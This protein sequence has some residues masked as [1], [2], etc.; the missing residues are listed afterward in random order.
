M[1]IHLKKFVFGLTL[2][3]LFS[4]LPS[5]AYSGSDVAGVNQPQTASLLT[6]SGRFYNT[7]KWRGMF[8][9]TGSGGG[10][11]TTDSWTVNQSANGTFT[12]T[13]NPG[14]SWNG[15]FQASVSVADSR[16]R[17]TPPVYNENWQGS[18]TIMNTA[19]LFIDEDSCTYSLSIEPGT[20]PVTHTFG[21]PP[22][23]ETVS[24]EWGPWGL[25]TA[26]RDAPLPASGRTLSSSRQLTNVQTGFG[27]S[28][29]WDITWSFECDTQGAL[30]VTPFRQNDP[31]WR[32]DLYD[33]STDTIWG[34]GCALTSL[35]MAIFYVDLA[36]WTP[37]IVNSNMIAIGGFNGKSVDWSVATHNLSG[38]DNKFHAFRSRS[39]NDV[40]DVLCMGYP[41][42]VGVKL[43]AGGVPGHFVIV[44]GRQGSEFLIS[45]PAGVHTKLSQYGAFETRGFVTKTR[46]NRNSG[47]CGGVQLSQ[48][49]TNA[50]DES[51]LTITAGSNVELLVVDPNG[52]RTGY[53]TSTGD[54]E[55]IPE[56]V[57][58]RDSLAND[59]TGAPPDEITHLVH[60]E[61]P[62]QGSYQIVLT[63]IHHGPY[64]VS[65]EPFS[66]DGSPQTPTLI[67]G[68]APVNS[69]TFPFQY[70]STPGPVTSTVLDN[71]STRALVQTGDNVMI[72][73]FIVQ[74]T[75][76][77][78]VIIRAIGP[79]LG[80][81]PYNIPNALA[82]PRLEL[83]NAAGAV[84]GSN[85]DWQHTTNRRCYHTEPSH[86]HSEQR[87]RSNESIRVGH[88]RRPATG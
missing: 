9:V 55:E 28:G 16:E 65:V 23:N 10:Q 58:F 36:V 87:P 39:T 34:K 25:A 85:D 60:I 20:I 52:R 5:S 13:L 40:D 71:I 73:G 79:E 78:R 43:S 46:W 62:V 33:H 31:R 27:I 2:I 38:G 50:D 54:L 37:R 84:I 1:K 32:A 82:N 19:D 30:P 68:T 42:I 21:P 88:H 22:G 48:A 80:A 59:Q 66:Q 53:R 12:L 56:S 76:P 29:N 63:G 8:T 57:Y 18:G 77:K 67:Q 47:Q 86:R 49:S 44:T 17:I 74:G 51:S 64:S 72:G 3:C 75:G 83:H 41:V 4:W 45:D 6:G 24:Y 14:I 15:S 7:Q 69:S 35:T 26:I 11:T 61:H 81:P 70:S